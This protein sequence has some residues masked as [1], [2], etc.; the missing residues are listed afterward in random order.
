VGIDDTEP[1]LRTARQGIIRWD[2]SHRFKVVRREGWAENPAA[3]RLES[4]QGMW[5]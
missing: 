4:K 3:L 1:V 2:D 5:S